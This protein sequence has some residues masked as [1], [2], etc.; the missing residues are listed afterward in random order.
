[1]V[2]FPNNHGFSLLKWSFWWCFGGTTI[3]GNTHMSE[4][5]LSAEFSETQFY[6][7]IS[8]QRTEKRPQ[9]HAFISRLLHD[10]A[11]SGATGSVQLPAVKSLFRPFHNRGC[12]PPFLSCTSRSTLVFEE[13]NY[14]RGSRLNSL[15]GHGW[16]NLQTCRCQASMP[17]KCMMFSVLE[18]YLGQK[19]QTKS[20]SNHLLGKSMEIRKF[21][22]DF[23][24]RPPRQLH[25]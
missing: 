11:W 7:V 14:V 17:S 23:N 21:V 5:L 8:Y 16:G 1:M 18:N 3:W 2:G 19:L 25:T 6:N 13:G 15:H 22:H 20:S 10:D 4:M 12:N 24:C 9:A